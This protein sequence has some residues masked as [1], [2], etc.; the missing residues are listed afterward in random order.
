MVIRFVRSKAPARP[1]HVTG[2][3]AQMVV[4]GV[5]G[6]PGEGDAVHQEQDA[7]HETRVEQ[8]FDEGRR[9][10]GLA[11]SRRHLHEQ[12]APAVRHFGGQSLDARDLVVAIDDPPVDL[13]AGQFQP[14]PAGGDPPLQVVGGIDSGDLPRVPVRLAVEEPDLF[15]VR[16]ERER[17]AELLGVVASL[18]LRLKGVDAGALG[19]DRRHGPPRAV[20]ERVV[21]PRAVRQRMLEQDAHAVGEIPG[22][23]P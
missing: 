19:L 10:A 18:I 4:E 13:D 3:V 6:L 14:I 8:P 5:L 11:G 7:G 20:T 12:L 22:R 9:R 21:G 16:Q 15:P 1:E 17:D 23:R 2:I